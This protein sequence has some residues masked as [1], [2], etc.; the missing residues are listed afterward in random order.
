M[1][2]LD[3]FESAGDSLA[4][5]GEHEKASDEYKRA[6]FLLGSERNTRRSS[7]YVKLGECARALGRSRVALNNFD[8]ALAI[9]PASERAYR[10]FVDIALAE[11]DFALIDELIQRRLS[12]LTNPERKIE[13][14]RE[15]F[16]LW[17]ELGQDTERALEALE[18]WLGF[19][20]TNREALEHKA[21]LERALSRFGEAIASLERLAECC[22]SEEA[23]RFLSDAAKLAL[24]ELEDR[25]QAVQLYTRATV[26]DPDALEA[27]LAAERLLTE[28]GALAELA[29][30]YEQIASGS[31]NPVRQLEVLRKVAR[32]GRGELKDLERAE[33]ALS[34][35]TELAP[36]DPELFLELATVQM[37]RGDLADALDR[38]RR[39]ALLRPRGEQAY[40]QLVEIFQGLGLTDGAYNA[41][42]ALE[43]LGEAEINESLLADQHRPEGLLTPRAVLSDADW[44]AALFVP[45]RNLVASE[46]LAWLSE[47]VLDWRRQ[48]AR[49]AN[50]FGLDER[51]R[52]DVASSTATLV[53]ALAWATRVLGVDVPALYLRAEV[54]GAI[55]ALLAES[56]TLVA[57]RSLGSGLELPE[58]AFLWGRALFALRREHRVIVAFDTPEA[59]A[60]LFDTAHAVVER[61]AKVPS[62]VSPE[63]VKALDR[64][65]DAPQRERVKALLDALGDARA[66]AEA[67]LGSYELGAARAG[68]LACGDVGIAASLSERFPF[69]RL[70]STSEQIDA[71]LTFSVS[72]AYLELRRRLGVAID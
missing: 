64:G 24:E 6:L 4:A 15:N 51:E 29:S 43:Y 17:G 11:R 20:P 35:A 16:R 56:P 45:E 63:L 32:L 71:L 23:S 68:L 62:E 12:M 38:A 67:L 1:S 57:S 26:A 52:Q 66:S 53:R 40:H 36:A 10:A 42:L 5:C 34:R 2:Q 69:G 59:L 14:Y 9:D 37:E 48:S 39:A 54:D 31:R 8:K 33:R 25:A 55:Q 70:K 60:R 41:A 46:L 49:K 7:L 30:L 72:D 28:D 61:R 19:D 27:A 3:A 47:P 22:S 21:L 50:G 18:R 65:W 13:L 58:L 44:A